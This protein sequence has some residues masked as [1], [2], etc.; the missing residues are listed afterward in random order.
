M[1]IKL[2]IETLSTEFCNNSPSVKVQSYAPRID[3]KYLGNCR[4]LT[5]NDN[6]SSSTD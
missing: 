2:T 1:K 6:R 5:E 3:S 4:F